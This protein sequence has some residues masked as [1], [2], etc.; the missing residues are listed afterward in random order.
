MVPAFA[1]L[2]GATGLAFSLQTSYLLP[3]TIA[4]LVLALAALGFRAQKRR[5]YSP[6]VFG[7]LAGGLVVTG[8]FFLKVSPMTY[9]GIGLLIAASLWNAWPKRAPQGDLIELTM[10]KIDA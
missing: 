1:G 6:L 3:V 8:K 2:L 5:G 7:T 4:T 9:G 10:R